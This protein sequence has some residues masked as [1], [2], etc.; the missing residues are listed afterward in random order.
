MQPEVDPQAQIIRCSTCHAV[1]PRRFLPL[2][3]VTGPSGTGKTTIVDAVQRLLPQWNAFE[4]DILWDSG[5]DWQTA[6]C[7]WLR[8]ADFINQRPNS[9]PTVLCGTMQPQNIRQCDCYPLFST[10]HWLA[11]WCR[12]DILAE[13]L[14]ARPAWRGCTEAFIAEQQ[15][16][17][18][19]L[20][21]YATTAFDPPLTILDTTAAPVAQTAQQ[22]HDWA[23]ERWPC[24]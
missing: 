21:E 16:Y 10:V 13:R 9:F 3:I 24:G 12:P 17:A 18:Q 11:L 5:G 14:R 7:N 8:I 22:I 23:V 19:W 1:T 4:T 2:F 15:R 20:V 6:H